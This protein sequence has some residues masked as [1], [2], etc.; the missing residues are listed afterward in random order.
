MGET[1]QSVNHRLEMLRPCH[2]DYCGASPILLLFVCLSLLC[3]I[4]VYADYCS[5][6]C[7]CV[8]VFISGARAGAVA[9]AVLVEWRLPDKT[10]TTAFPVAPTDNN[11][12][13]SHTKDK[14]EDRL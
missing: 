12:V 5:S 1:L 10:D 8:L 13:S 14:A 4:F 7:R 11:R 2:R 6:V 9:C 3:L